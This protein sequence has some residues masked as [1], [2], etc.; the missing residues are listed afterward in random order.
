MAVT[1]NCGNAYKWL[2]TAA[3]MGLVSEETITDSVVR[4]FTARYRLGMFD[5]DC[6]YDKIPYEVVECEKH[7]ELNRKMAQESIVL[8][9]NDGILPLKEDVRIAVIGPNADDVSV[10]LGN[11]NGTPSY[12]TTIL[13]GIQ[14]NAEGT[15][16]VCQRL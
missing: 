6:E 14:E 1:L 7:R 4:L 5:T 11:Y 3:T 10:L 12:Y 13:R 15:G 8:L 9:K 2:K 16:A